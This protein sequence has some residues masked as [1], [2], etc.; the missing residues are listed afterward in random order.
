[1]KFDG[2]KD[3]LLCWSD[4]IQSRVSYYPSA[5]IPILIC[6][7]CSSHILLFGWF[8]FKQSLVFAFTLT[9]RLTLK[10]S[11]WVGGHF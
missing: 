5:A 10:L 4:C 8:C 2:K 11:G 3:S 6:S 9:Q 1:M 7:D